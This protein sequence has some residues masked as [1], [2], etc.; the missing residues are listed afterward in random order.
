MET[1]VVFLKLTFLIISKWIG[2][3]EEQKKKVKEAVN[4]VKDGNKNKDA[5]AVTAGFDKLRRL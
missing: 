2:F 5:S 3:T 4:E 1:I